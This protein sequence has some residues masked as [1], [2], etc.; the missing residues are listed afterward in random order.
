MNACAA[1]VMKEFSD[2]VVSYGESDEYRYLG[3]RRE[4]RGR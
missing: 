3:E 2:I 4:E 1:S